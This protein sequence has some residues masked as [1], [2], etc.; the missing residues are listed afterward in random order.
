MSSPSSDKAPAADLGFAPV[1]NGVDF[2]D[3]AVDHLLT[4]HDARSLK[5]GV[6]HLQ[7]AIEVLVKVRLRREGWEQVF[8][9][10]GKADLHKFQRGDFHSVS[11]SDALTRLEELAEIELASTKAALTCLAYER[12][13]LMHFGSTSDHE[14]LKTLAGRALDALSAFIVDH[15]VPGAPPDETEALEEAQDLIR[16]ALAEI[17]IVTEARLT[18]LAPEL[19]AWP[20]IVIHCPECTQLAWTFDP[21]DETSCLFCGR[22]WGQEY[23]WEIA[24][25]YAENI[26]GESRYEAAQGN[27]G[28]SISM[29]PKCDEEALVD[30]AT[31]QDPDSFLTSAC[32]QCGFVAAD[33]LGSCGD[34]GRT[35][36]DP[37]GIW[38]P[39]CWSYRMAK[40]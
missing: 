10:P 30:V 13:R 32:F 29:C 24:P 38:C 15:M 17:A 28:W 37:D 2:L 27:S 9:N 6:L 1:V 8:S 26:L 18:R 22:G 36:L 25:L 12:N 4:S 20:G 40:D 11:L 33:E 35:I 14:V 23:G 7:A 34:C 3:S 5:Y 31:R 19:D 16:H 21:N 39:G